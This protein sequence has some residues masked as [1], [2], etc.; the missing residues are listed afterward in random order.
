[1]TRPAIRAGA[2][3][4]GYE[5]DDA[6]RAEKVREFL[7]TKG[8]Q[9]VAVVEGSLND[10]WRLTNSVEEA[11]FENRENVTPVFHAAQHGCRS[12]M[13]GDLFVIDGEI[14]M[15]ASMGFKKVEGDFA[16]LLAAVDNLRE[17][18]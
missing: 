5:R 10:A 1:M 16:D 8:Y 3:M 17:Q 11:W 6:A 4:V 14:S 18:F 9:R 7:T 12:S 13:V 2:D 15:V